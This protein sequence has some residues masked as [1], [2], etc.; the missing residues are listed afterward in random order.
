MS[1]Q[2][3]PVMPATTWENGGVFSANSIKLH[4]LG[5]RASPVAVL[6]DFRVRGRPFGPHL[7]QIAIRGADATEF[8]YEREAQSLPKIGPWRDK[9]DQLLLANEGKAFTD[10]ESGRFQRLSTPIGRFSSDRA[11]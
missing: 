9:L 11:G 6:D 1:V 3:S 7:D 8:R 5:E 10:L 4:G 2:L